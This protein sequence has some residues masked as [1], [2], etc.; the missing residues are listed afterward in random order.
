MAA[1]AAGKAGLVGL[2]RV[3]A[4]EFSGKGF[5]AIAILPGGTDPP[6]G[7]AFA[8][9]P[10]TRTFVEGLHALKR[11]ASPE[12]IAGSVLHFASDAFNFMMGAA[13]LV[14]GGI[15]SSQSEG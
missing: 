15:S 10:A 1:K 11:I 12:E 13:P 9:T 7:R 3:L 5:R 2:T 6:M 4:A 14:D 8:N